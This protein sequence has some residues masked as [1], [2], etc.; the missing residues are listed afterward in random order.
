M[1]LVRIAWWSLALLGATALLPSGDSVAQQGSRRPDARGPRV[2][3]IA[4]E[5]D[6]APALALS[7]VYA[8]QQRI[9]R[10]V[11]QDRFWLVSKKDIDN[12]FVQEWTPRPVPLA[13]YRELGKLVRADATVVLAVHGRDDSLDV[14]ASI[15]LTRPSPIDTVHFQAS[16]PVAAVDSLLARL[17]ADPTFRRGAR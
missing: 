16:S 17:L 13:E 2:A 15:V 4:A 5:D 11:S 7:I 9:P 1:T 14:V 10:M 8:A 6:P 3:V 12:S